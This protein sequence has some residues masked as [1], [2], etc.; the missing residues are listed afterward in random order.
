MLRSY[1][2]NSQERRRG[3][4]IVQGHRHEYG[5]GVSR[6][7]PATNKKTVAGGE[8]DSP[9][10]KINAFTDRGIKWIEAMTSA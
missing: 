2:G 5:N 10:N 9:V 8:Y 4:T 1:G 3:N 6:R 7:F